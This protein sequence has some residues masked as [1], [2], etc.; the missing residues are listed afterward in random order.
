MNLELAD[1]TT[2]GDAH[3][4]TWRWRVDKYPDGWYR[5]TWGGNGANAGGGAYVGVVPSKT[6]A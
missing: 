5:V 6:S 3:S 2:G 4:S 1:G